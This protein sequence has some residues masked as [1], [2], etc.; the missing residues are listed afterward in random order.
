MLLDTIKAPEDIRQL[1]IPELQTLADEMRQVIVET[2]SKTGGHLSSNLGV[3]EL[4]LALHHVFETPMAQVVW[5]VGHQCYP[6]KILT[7]RKEKLW[8]IRQN[9]GLSG[10]P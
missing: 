5:D 7:E 6:H 9:G 2:V 3:V 10:F 1:T 8:T 4:S